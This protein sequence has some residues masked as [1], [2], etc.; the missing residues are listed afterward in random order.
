MTEKQTANDRVEVQQSEIAAK[1]T[2]KQAF[3]SRLLVGLLTVSLVSLFVASYF[4]GQAG[5]L[6]EQVTTSQSQFA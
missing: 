4:A 1:A 2:S 5:A 3:Q 6:R